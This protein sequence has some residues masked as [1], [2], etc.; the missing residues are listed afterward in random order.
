M[1]RL[2]GNNIVKIDHSDK[3]GYKMGRII[4]N[5]HRAFLHCEQQIEFWENSLLSEMKGWIEKTF[6]KRD[7]PLID[8][9][10]FNVTM[11]NLERLYVQLPVQ[12]IHRDVHFGNFLF[13]NGVFSGYIDF[14]LSQRNIRIFDPCYFL[15]GLLSEE[16]TLDITDE[17]WF[18]ML[19]D[20]FR[21]YSEVNELS[22]QEIEAIP[23][24][25][26]SIELLFAAWFLRQD[27]KRCSENAVAIFNFVKMNE[28]KILSVLKNNTM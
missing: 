22:S 14:D 4:A 3:L 19:E 8:R 23:Y 5:L 26:Q 7:W 18:E 21:G 17:E 11:Q 27:D 2:K 12:L 16:E 1:E 24:V 20:V 6:E 13:D 15:L 28:K 9:E 10:L 25:M